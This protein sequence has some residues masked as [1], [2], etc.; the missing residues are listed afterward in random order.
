MDSRSPHPGAGHQPLSTPALI[1]A[2]HAWQGRRSPSERRQVVAALALLS[3]ELGLKGLHLEVTAPLLAPMRLGSGSLRRLPAERSSAPL[4]APGDGASLGQLWADGPAEPAAYAAHAISVAVDAVRAQRRAD[5]AEAHLAALDAAVQGIGGV[6]SLER[7]LQLIVD[8]V[9]E[10][11]D[12][13]YAALGIV[14]DDG[15]IERFITAGISAARRRRIGPLPRG[16]GLLGLIIEEHR[17]IRI[18]DIATDPRRHGFPPEHPEM[19]AFLGVPVTVRGRPIGN[20]YLTNKRGGIPFDE[21]DQLLVERFA[22][23]AGLAMENARLGERVQSLAVVDERERIARHLH[24]GI[25][26][27]IYGV[28]LALDEVPEIVGSE[29]ERAAGRVDEAIGSLQEAIGEIREFIYAL[30]VPRDG[31]ADLAAGVE[32]LADRLRAHA[33]LE[34]H[35]DIRGTDQIG[36][37]ATVELLAVVR[38]ALSNVVRHARA[39]RVTI[40]GRRRGRDLVLE[41]RDDGI[42]LPTRPIGSGHH[43]LHNMERRVERL[44]GTFEARGDAGTRI[45][46]ILPVAQQRQESEG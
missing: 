30:E 2:L 11:A 15:R 41:V 5:Q 37:E 22:R 17:A 25:I 39:R 16:R 13:Q 46:I 35:T 24:D 18:P 45:I 40:R 12:A 23:H 6:L 8:R 28:T 9:R 33:G 34:V 21:A 31:E 26:Q 44:G 43:G 10:L 29:P 4:T 36:A 42:G 3:H 38:E 20:L 19:H 14:G 27:R 32:A 7:V 1:A